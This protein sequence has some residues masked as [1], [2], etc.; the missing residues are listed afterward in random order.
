MPTS[1]E[2]S[3]L[4][5]SQKLARMIICTRPKFEGWI[6]RYRTRAS[7]LRRGSACS[8]SRSNFATRW[9][10]WAEWLHNPVQVQL[11]DACGS[12]GCGSG[13]YIHLSRVSELVLWTQP[14]TDPS[15]EQY[16][17]TALQRMGA[18]GFPAATWSMVIE[19]SANVPK[20]AMLQMANGR[21]LSDAWSSTV[22]RFSA[23]TNFAATLRRKLLAADSLETDAAIAKIEQ[24]SAWFA[25]RNHIAVD[26]RV[27]AIAECNARAEMLYF[28]GPSGDDWPALAEWNGSYYPLLDP[29]Q[30]FVPDAA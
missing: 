16:P 18:I 21:A 9:N 15:T 23:E 1:G 5:C 6:P 29:S 19:A 17:A 2:K 25:K 13:G 22:R 11:C 8:I 12:T 14:Q 10:E 3:G 7:P 27:V 28:D 26:G 4:K 20:L 24:W 30:F